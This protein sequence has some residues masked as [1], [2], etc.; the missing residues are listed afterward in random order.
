MLANSFIE[1]KE[2]NLTE[3]LQSKICYYVHK[4]C[5]HPEVTKGCPQESCCSPGYW[6]I[7][8]NSILN[9]KYTSHTK[10]IAFV[11]DLVLLTRGDT[12]REAENYTNI[13]MNKIMTWAKANKINFNEQKSKVMLM[14]RRKRKEQKEVHDCL[15]NKPLAQA[16]ALKYLGIIFDNKLTFREHINHITEK[17][18][19]L[20]F[21][22]SKSAKLNWGLKHEVKT[23]YKG[24]ILP[25]LTYGAPVWIKA[26][27][28]ECYKA[29]ITRVQ[30]LINIKIAK[31]YH[32][33]STEAL[34]IIT[35]LTPIIIKIDEI[36]KLYK[37]LRQDRNAQQILDNNME[38]KYWPHAVNSI[39][40][41]PESQEETHKTHVYTDGSK[42]EQGVG[43]GGIQYKLKFSDTWQTLPRRMSNIYNSFDVPA[44]YSSPL[45]IKAENLTV[46][47]ILEMMAEDTVGASSVIDI[48]IFPLADGP[49]IGEES[50]DE[51]TSDINHLPG[52][53]LRPTFEVNV[54]S[55][56]DVLIDN[57]EG[58]NP[59]L[60]TIDEIT[61]SNSYIEEINTE[62]STDKNKLPK[63]DMNIHGRNNY[64]LR[65][66]TVLF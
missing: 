45:K 11:D 17:C 66:N 16:N 50:G 59:R 58:S 26:M 60:S 32:T 41:N 18:T 6:N 12:I 39:R 9:L 5:N 4:Q 57:D 63:S 53:I 15:N 54:T 21:A 38:T 61:M 2:L 10:A 28:R 22:L 48:T 29:K 24:G 36:V 13:E 19:K 8:Y 49:V 65:K 40:F 44:L 47:E 46:Y 34:C 30:R 25:L 3:L 51:T 42:S 52:R 27:E 33:V 31:A 23:I 62:V 37:Y 14:T 20:I 35:G 55:A 56:N 7:Q 43:I 64:G 1:R